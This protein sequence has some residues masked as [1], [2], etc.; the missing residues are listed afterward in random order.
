VQQPHGRSLRARSR[1]LKF[2]VSLFFLPRRLKMILNMKGVFL[3]SQE[4]CATLVGS[5]AK[6]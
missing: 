6:T 3:L 1:R 2:A 5:T 4:P